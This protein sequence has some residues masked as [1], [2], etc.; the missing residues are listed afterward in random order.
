MKITYVGIP[1]RDRIWVG[2]CNNCESR[3]EAKQSELNH[4]TNDP[5]DGSFSWEKCPVCEKGEDTGY[6]GM[7]F[8]P[9]SL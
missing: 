3:A 7:L 6:G 8:H 4:I 2:E 5:R 1:A 9:K